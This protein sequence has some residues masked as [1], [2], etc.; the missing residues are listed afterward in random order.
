[1]QK[2]EALT[3]SHPHRDHFYDLIPASW[4]SKAT[5][6]TEVRLSW[7]EN[8]EEEIGSKKIQR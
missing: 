4:R 8:R 2:D 5:A 1:M 3:M 6:L 7:I